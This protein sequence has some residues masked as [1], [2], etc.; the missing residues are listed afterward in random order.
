MRNTVA[1]LITAT[2]LSACLH[3]DE[4][5]NGESEPDA[6]STPPQNAIPTIGG[7]P[8]PRIKF[9]EWYEFEPDAADRDGEPLMFMVQNQPMWTSFDA[10]TGRLFG[11]PAARDIGTYEDIIIS[12]SDGHSAASLPAFSITVS[13]S[14][15]GSVTLNWVPPT[16]NSDG[17]PLRGLAGYVIYYGRRSGTYTDEIR[18]E[19][20]GITSYVV[21]NLSPA[22]YYFVA[23]SF[24][25]SVRKVRIP[26]KSS[27][28]S[29][30]ST[31]RISYSPSVSNAS[32]T[33]A[34]ASTVGR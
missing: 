14:A 2:L 22:T 15:L 23:T 8:P 19:N 9:G 3:R 17:S 20:P 11:Q 4:T 33:A 13:Q 31:A 12:V 26:R 21:M 29:I 25:V 1:V 10:A 7:N 16:H 30:T 32:V 6:E 27:G 24:N 28:R 34:I 18:I 5:S